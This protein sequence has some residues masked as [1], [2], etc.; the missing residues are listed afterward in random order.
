[1]IHMCHVKINVNLLEPLAE[2]PHEV[3]TCRH[4]NSKFMPEEL[5]NARLTLLLSYSIKHVLCEISK[6]T[7]QSG[8][9]EGVFSQC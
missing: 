1:M 6:L 3:S 2:R 4:G 7:Q 5:S 8:S 9:L